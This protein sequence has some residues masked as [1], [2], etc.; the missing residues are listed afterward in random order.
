MPVQCPH[1][2]ITPKDS[3]V[4]MNLWKCEILCLNA[5]H[6]MWKKDSRRVFSQ[7]ATVDS[8]S[9][10]P[11][12]Q[13]TY[14]PK[15]IWNWSRLGNISYSLYSKQVKDTVEKTWVFDRGKGD[16][17]G[18]K[19]EKEGESKNK[20]EVDSETQKAVD[21]EWYSFPSTNCWT[22]EN[23]SCSISK[24]RWYWRKDQYLG[25]SSFQTRNKY[26]I[27]F[28]YKHMIKHISKWRSWDVLHFRRGMGELR[29]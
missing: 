22:W 13:Q 23:T 3:E 26:D 17:G 2:A 12:T 15:V 8:G 14:F 19:T 25:H 9:R 11:E 18:A 28:K 21:I 7:T 29:Q 24:T 4:D 6:E 16:R 1:K 10:Q 20:A 5:R 27:W